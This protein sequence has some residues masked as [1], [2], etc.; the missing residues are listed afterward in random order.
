MPI[1][2]AQYIWGGP[3][4][5][6]EHILLCSLPFI[7]VMVIILFWKKIINFS[8][9]NN[10]SVIVLTDSMTINVLKVFFIGIGTGSL[11]TFIIIVFT[12]YIKL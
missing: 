9:N 7:I 6:K 10:E 12:Y 4:I 1:I 2:I 11:G 5:H 3:K 8:L